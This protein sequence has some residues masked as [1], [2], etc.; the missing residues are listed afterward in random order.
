MDRWLDLKTKAGT[1]DAA[2]WAAS[3]AVLAVL[4][5][6]LGVIWTGVAW[7]LA[8]LPLAGI[9]IGGPVV[10]GRARKRISSTRTRPL[11]RPQGNPLL[12]PAQLGV[13][14]LSA[15]F[16]SFDGGGHHP[17][18][19][20]GST[21]VVSARDMGWALLPSLPEPDSISLS[22]IEGVQTS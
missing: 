3:W 20:A 8:W 2:L 19:A 5:L 21:N 15:G 6:V 17:V 7:L 1:R 11:R 9:L 13:P 16:F 18:T 4:S 10:V 22:K 12:D 14:F